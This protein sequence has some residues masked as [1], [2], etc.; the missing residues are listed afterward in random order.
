MRRDKKPVTPPQW[1]QVGGGTLY[2]QGTTPY[3][4]GGWS[5]LWALAGQGASSLGK[6]MA[7]KAAKRFRQSFCH[8]EGEEEPAR[9]K[10]RRHRKSQE[11][12]LGF[13]AL[14]WEVLKG[15][16]KAGYQAAR[17]GAGK[18]IQSDLAQKKAMEFISPLVGDT[19]DKLGNKVGGEEAMKQL[20]AGA[21]TTYQSGT[22]PYQEG[23]L[24]PLLGLGGLIPG[25]VQ[26]LGA[27]ATTYQSGTDPYQEGGFLPLLGLGGLIPGLM[28]QLGAGASSSS[29]KKKR[30]T[31]ITA[32]SIPSTLQRLFRRQG[33]R[34]VGVLPESISGP[35]VGMGA[36]SRRR[37]PSSHCFQ[38]L[39]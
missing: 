19:L 3:Q 12:G 18:A 37:R 2:Q 16:G 7:C 31:P 36:R 32:S 20:G 21:T 17:M 8:Q 4:E 22:D 35:Q 13:D 15:L 14:G 29:K 11:G 28:K 24:L 1:V 26:Q 38:G 23:G 25:L 27:G 33:G 30:R 5:P 6:E 10:K 9:K 39:P 34:N